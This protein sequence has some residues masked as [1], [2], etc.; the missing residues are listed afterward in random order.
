MK[1]NRC[2]G[3]PQAVYCVRLF[4]GFALSHHDNPVHLPHGNQRLVAFVALGGLVCRSEVAG[5][6]W[7]E[8]DDARANGCLRTAIWQIHR[9]CPRLLVSYGK[10]LGLSDD[11]YVDTIDFEA[12]AHCVF[13]EPQSV[14]LVEL[15]HDW[16]R[17]RLLPGWYDEW[18][19]VAQERLWQLQLHVLEAAGEELLCRGKP[20]PALWAASSAANAEPLRESAHRLVVR[21]HISEGNLSAATAHYQNYVSMLRRELGVQPTKQ[22]Q[23]LMD[24]FSDSLQ[25]RK[26]WH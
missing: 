15:T 26:Q 21:I 22:F 24:G 5:V 12:L 23:A 10:E 2:R 3:S 13:R 19:I 20:G 1:C 4:G 6:L 18:V 17:K 9:C 7:P 11:T 8:V 14:P 16:I 25:S